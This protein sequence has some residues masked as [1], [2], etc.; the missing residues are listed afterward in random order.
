MTPVDLEALPTPPHC[1]ADFCLVPLGTSSASVSNEIAAVQRLMKQSG[2]TYSLHSAG[3]TVEGPWD[4]V[5]R[6]IG[7]AHS[8]LHASG[9]T[10]CH[11]DIRVGSRTDKKESYV[12]KVKAVERLLA[13]GSEGTAS[14]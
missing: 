9:V 1:T 13:K 7:Q 3:T 10:R 5:M 6:V 4:E 8:M 14:E 2:L 11:T 12:E